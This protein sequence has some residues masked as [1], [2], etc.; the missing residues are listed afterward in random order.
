MVIDKFCS[1]SI[2]PERIGQTV[3]MEFLPSDFAESYE[4]SVCDIVDESRTLNG[5]IPFGAVREK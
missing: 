4:V 5:E 2:W 3:T 1:A